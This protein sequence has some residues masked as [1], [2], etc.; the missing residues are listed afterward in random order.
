MKALNLMGKKFGRLQVVASYHFRNN[1]VSRIMWV[2]QCSCGNSV[3]TLANGLTSNHT[4]SCGCLKRDL[5]IQ[6]STKHGMSK[7]PEYYIWKAMKNRCYNPKDKRF[8]NYGG[9]GIKICDRWL[10]NFENFFSDMGN[11]PNGLSIERIN[12]NGNYEPN[13][14][15]WATIIEQANN[16]SNNHVNIR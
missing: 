15:K 10:F 5:F 8:K 13:N 4:R 1:T 7:F 3:E 14:C 6:R 2:C 12:N 16:R 9:R 11:K